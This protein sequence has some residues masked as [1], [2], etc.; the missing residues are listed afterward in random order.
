MARLLRFRPTETGTFIDSTTHEVTRVP[1]VSEL[2]PVT[3]T[4][5][6]AQLSFYES[7]TRTT[8]IVHRHQLSMRVGCWRRGYALVY[9]NGSFVEITDIHVRVSRDGR[10]YTAESVDRPW[11]VIEVT[12]AE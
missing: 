11:F 2:P 5:R 12:T 4:V 7:R 9:D 3:M 10:T 1:P 8:L 6:P